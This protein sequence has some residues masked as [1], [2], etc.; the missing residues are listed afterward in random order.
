M[1]N[2]SRRNL[3]RWFTLSMGSILV[4]FAGVI[5]YQKAADELEELDQLLYTKTRVMAAGVESEVRQG[6]W[7]VNLENVPLLGSNP[8]LP[9]TDLVYARWYDTERKLVQFFGTTPPERL[10]LA[11]DR[12][13]WGVLVWG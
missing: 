4:V 2:Q 11:S 12:G 8:P 5:Y 6:Q 3:A 13:K 10:T 9:T 7:Q 1:F